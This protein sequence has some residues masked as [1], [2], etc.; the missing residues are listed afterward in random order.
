MLPIE[1]VGIIIQEAGACAGDNEVGL[2]EGG[3]ED[4]YHF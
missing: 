2:W 4:V 3:F 1:G